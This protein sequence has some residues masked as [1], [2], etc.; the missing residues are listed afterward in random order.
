MIKGD[1][2][3]YENMFGLLVY[4]GSKPSSPKLLESS[5]ENTLKEYML[6]ISNNL[7][8]LIALSKI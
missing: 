7:N 5:I 2:P 4:S 6:S 3:D 1:K 8:L